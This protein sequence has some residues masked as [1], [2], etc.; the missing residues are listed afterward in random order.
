MITISWRQPK[1]SNLLTLQIIERLKTEWSARR[2]R[3]SGGR[4]YGPNLINR[5]VSRHEGQQR[6]YHAWPLQQPS[7]RLVCFHRRGRDDLRRS[8][9]S[10]RDEL[11]RDLS[12]HADNPLPCLFLFFFRPICAARMRGA[13][14]SRKKPDFLIAFPLSLFLQNWEKQTTHY[15][16]PLLLFIFSSFPPLLSSLP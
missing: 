4:E 8:L 10:A 11:G 15:W 13:Q 2:E 12:W 16:S 3:G 7:T 14:R 6:L 9:G 5:V 1:E